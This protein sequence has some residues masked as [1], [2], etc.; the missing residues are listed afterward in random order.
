[1][2][3]RQGECILL[4]GESG[5]GKT[6]VTK[7]V[8][9]L[10]PHFCEQCQLEGTVLIQDAEVAG[11]KLYKIAESVGSVFQNPK[12]SF[13][14]WIQIVKLHLEWRIREKASQR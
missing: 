9:G 10:I 13:F 11:T 6:T 5:C 3:I 14:N 7:L 2:E 12:S 1:M 8:N 4:C